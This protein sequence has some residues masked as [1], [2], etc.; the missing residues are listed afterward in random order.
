VQ[1]QKERLLITGFPFCQGVA[2]SVNWKDAV[3][4]HQQ[5]VAAFLFC[6][7]VAL[8]IGKCSFQGSAVFDTATLF[9]LPRLSKKGQVTKPFLRLGTT[10][11]NQG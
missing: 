2:C 10:W 1:H 5:K 8:R 6:S 3:F 4:K 9:L 7:G 11:K